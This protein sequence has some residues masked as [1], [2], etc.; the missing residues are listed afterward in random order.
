MGHVSCQAFFACTKKAWPGDGDA[1][2]VFSYHMS[3]IENLENIKKLGVKRF[4]A[5]EKKRWKCKKC[6]GVVNVHKAICSSC[7]SN[8][9]GY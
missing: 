6:G 4:V 1:T 2:P 9:T 5:N 8:L 3:M 7:G